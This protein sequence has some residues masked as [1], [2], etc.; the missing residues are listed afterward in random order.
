MSK[1]NTGAS[2]SIK[3]NESPRPALF[4]GI[5]EQY[6]PSPFFPPLLFPFPTLPIPNPFPPHLFLSP[7][8]LLPPFPSAFLSYI[9]PPFLAFSL[10]PSTSSPVN[11][12]SPSPPLIQ[13]RSPAERCW[14]LQR[15]WAESGH[16]TVI[17]VHF[18]L[19]RM[20]LMIAIL[21]SFPY[22]KL[23]IC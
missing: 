19:K 15:V 5:L 13:L 12:S 10:R 11:L 23:P 3:V 7:T 2:I 18:E 17:V 20:L 14:L 4:K 1:S 8:L 6:N 9:I 22:N 21:K 16:Q